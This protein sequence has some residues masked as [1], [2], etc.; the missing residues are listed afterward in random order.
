M[1]NVSAFESRE[2]KI[3]SDIEEQTKKIG[4]VSP[5]K[6]PDRDHPIVKSYVQKIEGTYDVSR[7][8]KD[9]DNAIDLL[10]IAYN[11]TPQEEGS[12]RVKISAIM[13]K[14]IKAQQDS[15]LT[16]RRA[17]TVAD[18]VLNLLKN[19]VPDWIDIKK[20]KD[21]AEIKAFVSKDLIALA[22]DIKERALGIKNELQTIATTYT[23]IITETSAATATSETALGARIK[24]KE[25][26]EKEIAQ[27]NAER[28]RLDSLVKDL[29]EEVEN[30]NKKARD[31]EDRASTA[32]SR[33]FIMQIVQVG[34]QMVSSAIP[35]I[36]MAAT[37][38]GASILAASTLSTVT[39]ATG[40]KAAATSQAKPDNTDDA[41]K[42]R[43][44]ISN[45]KRDLDESEKK[46]KELKDKVKE[47]R[48]D[49]K[50]EKDKQGVADKADAETPAAEEEKA[51]DPAAV[52]AIKVR[53]K[54]AKDDLAK[55][56]D[57]S[58]KLIGALAGL[59]ASLEALDKGLGK[60]SA[61]QKDHAAGLREI[62][63][64][65]LDKAEAYE[66]ERRSQ[67]SEL[68]KINAL[69]KG[70]RTEEETI[71][72]AIKSLSISVKA[73][74]RTKEII[75][76][77][78]FFFKSFAEFMD[79]VSKEAKEAVDTFDI[80]VAK[81][82]VRETVLGNLIEV[83]DKFF[84][85]QAGEW[86]ATKIVSDKF[87]LSFADGWS[88][89]NKLSGKYIT[90][91]ELAAYLQTASV[92]LEEIA[93]EREAAANDKIL[94]L[95]NYRNQLRQDAVKSGATAA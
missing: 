62:Q 78:A 11:T 22:K 70:K 63:M 17:M 12:I 16:M 39:K 67:A 14:L 30:F 71:E 55:E 57:K 72:L 29:Q 61:E 89:L 45:N 31:Y 21:V 7:A 2:A 65:M 37:G 27:T 53:L 74:K 82:K 1:T 84:I 43:V 88:K 81:E 73:L 64:K 18:S 36:A 41:I 19:N 91:D 95:N 51:D 66:K 76:E 9:T 20:D 77:I 48:T 24:G 56:E 35:A 59:Q 42:A 68:V 60:L 46:V 50:S 90:G 87:N 32:E 83:V 49:L 47:I 40:D 15:E 4:A 8:K 25:A 94:A 6:L 34:A 28:A 54:T 79:G 93:A 58:K 92:K 86:N 69:L 80:F 52:K 5:L 3:S 33:A 23:G 38:G 13:D 75:E 85:T 10:Y 26:I 44:E